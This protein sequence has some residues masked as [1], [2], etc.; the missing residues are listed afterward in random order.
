M[1][2]KTINDWETTRIVISEEDIK[3]RCTQHRIF[4]KSSELDIFVKE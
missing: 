3:M 1:E 2:L 4:E